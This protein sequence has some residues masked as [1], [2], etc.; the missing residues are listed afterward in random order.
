MTWSPRVECWQMM[1]QSW[2][3]REL[4]CSLHSCSQVHFREARFVQPLHPS[5]FWIGSLAR[6][7]LFSGFLTHAWPPVRPPTWLVHVPLNFSRT[8]GFALSK[9]QFHSH[10]FRLDQSDQTPVPLVSLSG[11]LFLAELRLSYP[12]TTSKVA[13]TTLFTIGTWRL[14]RASTPSKFRFGLADSFEYLS[15]LVGCAWW[16]LLS[17]SLLTSWPSLAPTPLKWPNSWTC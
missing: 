9:P 17:L 4:S 5:R 3:P 11:P 8:P 14:P 2:A 1:K 16:D 10:T 6:L 12:V 13:Q 15:C 7:A